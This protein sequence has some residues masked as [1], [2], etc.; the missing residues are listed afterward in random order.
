VSSSEREVQEE[1]V[2]LDASITVLERLDTLSDRARADLAAQRARRAELAR[3]LE[4]L[5]GERER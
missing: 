3:T 4:G 5:R 1:L 2:R